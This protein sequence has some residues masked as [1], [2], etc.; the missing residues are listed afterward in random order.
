MSRVKIAQCL[1]PRRHC[2]V[3]ISFEEDQMTDGEAVAAIKLQFTTNAAL[4]PRCGLCGAPLE[5]CGYEVGVTRFNSLREAMPHLVEQQRRQLAHRA[6]LD[7]LGRS[8]DAAR[9]N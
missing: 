7:R 3:A 8:A 1:C 2:L 5:E 4:N 9:R 6:L